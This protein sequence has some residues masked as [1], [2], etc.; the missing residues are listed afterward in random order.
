MHLLSFGRCLHLSIVNGFISK[1]EITCIV[2]PVEKRKSFKEF[3][4]GKGK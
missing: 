3:W 4:V 2:A 1:T